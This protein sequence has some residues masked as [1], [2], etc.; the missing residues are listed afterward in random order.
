MPTTS[1]TR[2]IAA[3]H[4]RVWDTVEDPHHMPRWWPGVK[5]MEDVRSERFT[6]VFTT[7]R[8]RP[9]RMDFQV[10]ASEPP[11]RRCWTQ[12]VGGTPFERVLDESIV[13]I[14][15]EPV[16]GGTEVTIAQRQKLRGYSRTGGIL[17]RRATGK[18]LDEALDGLQ[19][20]CGEQTG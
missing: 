17:L 20:I 2:T 9:V 12:E 1:R 3:P 6:Q 4:Q 16:D 19:R 15:L 18:K 14:L 7:K 10:L 11:W 8:G 5:R 13:E